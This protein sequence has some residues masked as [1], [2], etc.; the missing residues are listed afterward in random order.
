M[1]VHQHRF[2]K[3][4]WPLLIEIFLSVLVSLSDT[5]MLYGIGQTAVAAVGSAITYL[6]FINV[7]FIILSAGMLTVFTQYVGANQAAGESR[8]LPGQPLSLT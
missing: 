6:N 5:L 8:E 4:F 1:K 2:I 7:A 3:V